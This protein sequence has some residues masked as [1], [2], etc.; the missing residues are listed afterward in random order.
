[1]NVGACAAHYYYYLNIGIPVFLEYSVNV[2][3]GGC[4]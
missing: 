3:N 4:W 2:L 1:M